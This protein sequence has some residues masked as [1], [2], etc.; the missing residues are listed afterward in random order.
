M[1][2]VEKQL[3]DLEVSRETPILLNF[4]KEIGRA[5]LYKGND[6]LYADIELEDDIKG[7]F[8]PSIGYITFQKTCLP[9]G[10]VMEI[11]G[12]IECLSLGPYPNI[13]ESIRTI[14]VS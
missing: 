6:L 7:T 9:P 13:D 10:E 3:T 12:K 1:V 4:D 2:V 14:T 8:Y 5:S 11:E